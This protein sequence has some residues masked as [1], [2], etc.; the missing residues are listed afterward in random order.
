MATYGAVW[1]TDAS[2]HPQSFGLHLEV[3]LQLVWGEGPPCR[4][5]VFVLISHD[6]GDEDMTVL[7]ATNRQD[8]PRFSL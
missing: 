1:L 6:A 7:S 2:T 5:W 3:G 8:G 4:R